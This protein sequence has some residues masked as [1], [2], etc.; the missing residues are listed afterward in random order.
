[1]QCILWCQ[2]LLTCMQLDPNQGYYI[3]CFTQEIIITLMAAKQNTKMNRSHDKIQT[4]LKHATSK[5]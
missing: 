2:E 4:R 1:M 5:M 3:F